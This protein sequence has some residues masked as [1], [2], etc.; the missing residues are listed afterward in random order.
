MYFAYNTLFKDMCP[1]TQVERDKMEI[2]PYII[3]IRSIIY[4]MLYTR[5]NISYT[6]SITS[7]HKSNSS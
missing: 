4:A 2:I 5:P 7:R 6:L 3:D 1:K